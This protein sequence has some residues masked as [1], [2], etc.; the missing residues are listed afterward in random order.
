MRISALAESLIRQFRTFGPM[1]EDFASDSVL[2]RGLPSPTVPKD[3]FRR[4]EKSFGQHTVLID[5]DLL[6]FLSV[7]SFEFY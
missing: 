2:K 3:F 1:C 6:D 7:D 4:P 5:F